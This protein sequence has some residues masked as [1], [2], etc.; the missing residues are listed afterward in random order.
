METPPRRI[1][2]TPKPTPAKLRN[3]EEQK[4]EK[5]PSSGNSAI[6]RRRKQAS[7]KAREKENKK[8]AQEIE[9]LNQEKANRLREQLQKLQKDQEESEGEYEGDD[10][11]TVVFFTPKL[12]L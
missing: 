3:T 5:L 1:T 12:R 9:R 7:E 11:N 4:V 8:R 10:D 2:K 6:D